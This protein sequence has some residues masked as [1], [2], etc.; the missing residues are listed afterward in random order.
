MAPARLKAAHEDVARIQQSR[1]VLPPLPG[2]NDYRAILHA[3]AED[4]AHTGGTRPEMLADA[5]KVGVSA[6]LLSNHFR[7]P[8]D[9][10][11]DSWRGLHEGVLFIPGSEDRGFLLLPHA[12]DRRPH[13]RSHALVHRN[14]QRPTG[15]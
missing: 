1:A 2:L 10:I 3:H 11:T 5:K 7:P 13:E 6:I 15:D 12:V 4:S 14:R 9:F 8:T